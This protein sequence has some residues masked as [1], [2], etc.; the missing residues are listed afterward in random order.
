MHCCEGMQEAGQEIYL[1][2]RRVERKEKEERNAQAE[3]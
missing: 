1:V 3:A 2:C